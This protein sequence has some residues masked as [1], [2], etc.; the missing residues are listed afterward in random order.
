MMPWRIGSCA[1]SSQVCHKV[2]TQ[3]DAAAVIPLLLRG[4]GALRW[5]D[6]ITALIIPVGYGLYA[7]ARGAIDGWYAY[8]FL[9]PGTLSAAQLAV[10]M[11]GLTLGVLA[12]ALLLIAV[13]KLVPSQ[14]Q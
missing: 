8:P 14:A 4:H 1:G 3:R 11:A 10:N 2:D 6:G 12:L 5:R 13:A 9:D 7:L